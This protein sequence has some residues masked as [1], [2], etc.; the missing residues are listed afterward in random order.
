[1]PS[2]RLPGWIGALTSTDHKRIGANL[3]IASFVF[4]LGGGVMA[5][6]MRSQLAQANGTFLSNESYDA[7]FTMHGST[8]IYLF[9]TPMAIAL[10]I[11]L[12]PLQ[13]GA[14]NI[15]APRI[16]LAGF[17]TWLCGGLVMQSGWLPP[18]VRAATAGLT[19]P[20]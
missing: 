5:L 17:W 20:R 7:L 14:A 4:F 15:S 19:S 12:V 3:F 1:M 11:Y 8:M 6:L 16:A 13:I 10:G 18:V 2:T 9:V